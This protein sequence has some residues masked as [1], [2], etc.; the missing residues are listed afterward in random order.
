M[1]RR[2]DPTNLSQQDAQVLANFIADNQLLLMDKAKVYGDEKNS[3]QTTCHLVLD[4]SYRE[5]NVRRYHVVSPAKKDVLG[6]GASSKVR[7]VLGYVDIDVVA[8]EAHFTPSDEKA[9]KVKNTKQAQ[10]KHI[11]QKSQYSH[12][13]AK[14]EYAISEHFPQMGMQEPI[15]VKR[16]NA[17]NNLGLFAK[18]YFL[19]NKLAGKN[20]N[21]AV[22]EYIYYQRPTI[23]Q[24]LGQ[25][26][27]PVLQAYKE[28]IADKG[29]VHRDVK[30]DNIRADIAA[31]GQSTIQ[32]F[33]IESCLAP[34]VDD[35]FYGSAGYLP[36]ELAEKDLKVSQARDIFALGV[37]LTACINPDLN[38]AHYYPEERDAVDASQMA[39]MALYQIKQNGCYDAEAML[40][41]EG[42][43]Y[44]LFECIVCPQGS[45]P[46]Q[47]AIK[48][49][50]KQMTDKDPANRP[51]IE[52]VIASLQAVFNHLAARTQTDSGEVPRTSW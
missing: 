23:G 37:V 32:F 20:L 19:V 31:Q 35:K 45:E 48:T 8:K 12:K 43:A 50:L 51:P 46:E 26:V 38:P 1:T 10:A 14:N 33:D 21:E 6:T 30:P 47:E 13:Q 44:E 11:V 42:E 18:S 15:K 4:R 3:L 41:K 36:P 52:T 39:A 24:L 7:S 22:E 34:G 28:Q 17:K 29:L 9:L 49:L 40:N 16:N 25:V 5:A 27:L 2:I